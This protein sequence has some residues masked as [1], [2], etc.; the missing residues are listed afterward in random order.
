MALVGGVETGKSVCS[1]LSGCLGVDVLQDRLTVSHDASGWS[2][3][4]GAPLS[5]AHFWD[6]AMASGFPSQ[7][8]FSL[9]E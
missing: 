4:S 6:S 3:P 9:W 5:P 2:T 8:S 7:E 1:E